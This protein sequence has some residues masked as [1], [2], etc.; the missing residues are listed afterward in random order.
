MQARQ[1]DGN[2]LSYLFVEPD[3]YDD[4]LEYP[5][6]VLLHG[7]G[8]SMSDLAG[9]A[10]AIDRTGYVYLFPNAPIPMQIGI[11]MTGYAW[12][13]PGG[14]GTDRATQRAEDLLASFFDE[15]ME[16]HGIT[17]GGMVMGGFSQGGTMTYRFGLPRPEM[18]AGLV[19]LSGRLCLRRTR[20][21]RVCR[22]TGIS[23]YSWPTAPRTP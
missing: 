1:I 13:P 17:E 7:Y 18:F 22:S 21:L 11:G 4:T 2:S 15:V 3:D 19:I 20:F 8:A 6:V 16:R 12:T 9:L 10:P 14:D 5:T 23:R